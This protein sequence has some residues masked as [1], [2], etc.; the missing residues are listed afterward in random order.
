MF[1]GHYEADGRKELLEDIIKNGIDL[2]IYGP[3]W[4]K[5]TWNEKLPD[6]IFP[7]KAVRG[8]DYNK[9]LNAA[10]IALCFFSRLNRDSYTR[11]CFEI[12]AS[13]TLLLSEHSEDIESLYQEGKE[14][15][16]FRNSNELISK[17]HLYLSDNN[18]RTL[19]A[20]KGRNR[21]INDGYDVFSRIEKLTDYLD[22]SI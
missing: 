4:D 5:V 19:V 12:P 7:I 22:S 15:G 21:A 14:A 18:L 17:I 13:G 9:A 6:N 3:G 11:R 16:F 10:K 1:I 2:K 8:S 20:N